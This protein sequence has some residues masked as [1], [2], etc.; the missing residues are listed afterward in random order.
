MRE[1]TLDLWRLGVSTA[2]LA[3]GLLV[4]APA[5]SRKAPDFPRGSAKVERIIQT[6]AYSIKRES[7]RP[8]FARLASITVGAERAGRLNSSASRNFQ[9]IDVAAYP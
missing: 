6:K 3:A 5:I 8:E 2:A 9:A 4:A 1:A 7:A